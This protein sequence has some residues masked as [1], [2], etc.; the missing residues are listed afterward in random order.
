LI[1]HELFVIRGEEI[2]PLEDRPIHPGGILD[3]PPD[4]IVHQPWRFIERANNKALLA[5]VAD[6]PSESPTYFGA[7][8]PVQGPAQDSSHHLFGAL[9]QSARRANPDAGLTHLA[10][11]LDAEVYGLVFHHR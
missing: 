3:E 11:L 1:V 7:P 6:T 2:I 4:N 9:R 5:T 8:F 10:E